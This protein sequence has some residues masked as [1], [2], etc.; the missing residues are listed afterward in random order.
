MYAVE[1]FVMNFVIDVEGE[2]KGRFRTAAMMTLAPHT[3]LLLVLSY[4]D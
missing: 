1:F 2:F 3:P 4:Q